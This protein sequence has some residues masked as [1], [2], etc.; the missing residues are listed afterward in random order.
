G[1]QCYRNDVA[2]QGA[3]T[4]TYVTPPTIAED[5]GARFHVRLSGTFCWQDSAEAMLS[6]FTPSRPESIGLTWLG[7]GG[8][9]GPVPMLPED[10]TGVFPQAYW[11]NLAGRTN[12]LT[13]P[14]N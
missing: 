10:I 14:T 7:Q 4:S 12:T 6:I 13:H 11:N 5:D 2:I 8:D 9:G 3:T 1:V